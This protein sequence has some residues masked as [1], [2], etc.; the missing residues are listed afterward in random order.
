MTP[1]EINNRILE[2]EEARDAANTT[3]TI[4]RTSLSEREQQVKELRASI[5]SNMF[6]NT[7]EHKELQELI[8]VKKWLEIKNVAECIKEG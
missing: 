8:L 1:Q 2:L 5:N 6:E 3:N 7:K 4:L